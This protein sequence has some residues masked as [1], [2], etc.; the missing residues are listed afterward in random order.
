MMLDICQVPEWWIIN[1]GTIRCN[2]TLLPGTTQLQSGDIEGRLLSSGADCIIANPET[3]AKVDSLDQARLNLKAKII[4]GGSKVGWISWDSLYDGAS[5]S[6]EAVNT[7]K[8]DV[9]QVGGLIT[10]LLRVDIVF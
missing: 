2:V 8:D 1:V 3:A 5:T 7:H 10:G 9:M 4:V 6:H